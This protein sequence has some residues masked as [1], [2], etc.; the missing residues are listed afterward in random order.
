MYS[1]V[2]ANFTYLGFVGATFL[3]MVGADGR[4]ASI[5][6]AMVQT[7]NDSLLMGFLSCSFFIKVIIGTTI[8][9]DWKIQKDHKIHK[10]LFRFT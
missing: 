5:I 1:I 2:I 10:I 7:V 9:L 3:L 8:F 6:N 4:A